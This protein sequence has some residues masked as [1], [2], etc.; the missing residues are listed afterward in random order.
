MEVMKKIKRQNLESKSL[1]LRQTMLCLNSL[2]KCPIREHFSNSSTH[3]VKLSKTTSQLEINIFGQYLAH[4]V[5]YYLTFQCSRLKN[6]P[7]FATKWVAYFL[8]N[9][10]RNKI[11]T[12]K[13]IKNRATCPLKYLVELR[14]FCCNVKN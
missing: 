8:M 1:I 12:T 2:F 3:C 10:N 6:H 5:L 7:L 11:Y 14:M 13:N 9:W 4:F